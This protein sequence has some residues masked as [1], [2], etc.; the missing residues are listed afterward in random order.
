MMESVCK[1]DP[2][3]DKHEVFSFIHSGFIW[4]EE[5]RIILEETEAAVAT[6]SKFVTFC[7]EWKETLKES[8]LREMD[9]ALKLISSTSN[10]IFT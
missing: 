2:E 7:E 4:K 3:R 6:F 8:I 10:I 5:L 9:A 1:P